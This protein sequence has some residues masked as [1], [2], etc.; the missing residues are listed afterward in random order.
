MFAYNK[1]DQFRENKYSNFIQLDTQGN[2]ILEFTSYITANNRIRIRG[3][4]VQ[5]FGLDS[6]RNHS[7]VDKDTFLLIKK[8]PLGAQSPQD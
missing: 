2:V 6:S 1:T 4:D 3:V 7:V 5:R 8:N